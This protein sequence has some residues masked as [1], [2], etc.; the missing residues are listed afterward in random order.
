MNICANS[1]APQ[2]TLTIVHHEVKH[3][4]DKDVKDQFTWHDCDSS[5]RLDVGDV[6]T[7]DDEAG[8]AMSAA[9]FKTKLSI[10]PER[11]PRFSALRD[12][13]K[14][15]SKTLQLFS[16]KLEAPRNT[17]DDKHHA[18]REFVKNHTLPTH[19][20]INHCS[21]MD[22][23]RRN[24]CDAEPAPF[25]LAVENPA[26]VLGRY[27]G[28]DRA[29]AQSAAV[30]ERVRGVVRAFTVYTDANDKPR[31]LY[32]NDRDQN[33]LKWLLSASDYLRL[34]A[35]GDKT[36][37]QL[38]RQYDA[39]AAEMRALKETVTSEVDALKELRS[40]I[41][42]TILQSTARKWLD[43]KTDRINAYTI[44]KA[45]GTHSMAKLNCTEC[46]FDV[47]FSGA[48]WESRFRAEAGHLRSLHDQLQEPARAFAEA[49]DAFATKWPNLVPHPERAEGD[50]FADIRDLG[51]FR[52]SGVLVHNWSLTC[53]ESG[54]DKCEWF[55]DNDI[56]LP[57]LMDAWTGLTQMSNRYSNGTAANGGGVGIF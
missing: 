50:L 55:G 37:P 12:Q 4:D 15:L 10:A 7:R 16:P 25:C 38:R 6:V 22:K 5:G 33:F 30:E 17:A 36:N 35:D 41:D 19:I 29:L 11:T 23:E 13:Q 32:Q 1:K 47:M 3:S 27:L 56:T 45:Y 14:A 8:G 24:V 28:T 42:T 18:L 21:N 20:L 53:D 26:Q 51:E 57:R 2:R 54:V 49:W 31:Y 40:T 44:H 48:N 46:A 9:E 39:F 52:K 43:A 34:A